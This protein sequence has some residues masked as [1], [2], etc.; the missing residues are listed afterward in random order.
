MRQS[1]NSVIV[2]IEFCC[3]GGDADEDTCDSGKRQVST[4][5]KAFIER[6]YCLAEPDPNPPLER[7][8]KYPEKDCT[9]LVT[10][11]DDFF[12]KF[13]QV[14]SYYKFNMV[15][16]MGFH[17]K[18]MILAGGC[19]DTSGKPEIDKTDH[20]QEAYEFGRNLYGGDGHAEM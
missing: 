18:G 12:W 17:D 4:R 10:S 11:A 2:E 6:F 16:Y 13:E 1:D 14:V 7:Y 8:E 20:L 5:I 15:N 9:L 3:K 19:C